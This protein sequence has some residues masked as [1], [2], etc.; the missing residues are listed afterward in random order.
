M[1]T[2]F[3]TFKNNIYKDD[4]TGF[5]KFNFLPKMK[6]DFANPFGWITCQGS[7]PYYSAD[8]PLK[9]EGEWND[10]RVFVVHKTSIYSDNAMVIANYIKNHCSGFGDKLSLNI[11]TTLQGRLF[12]LLDVPDGAEIITE[13]V[14]GISLKKANKLIE[15]LNNLTHQQVV[16]DY[17]AKYDICY[18]SLIKLDS[19]YGVNLEMPLSTNPYKSGRLLDL[20]FCDVD[21][22]AFYYNIEPYSFIRLEGLI[23]TA[24]RLK[25]NEGHTIA[26]IKDIYKTVNKISLEDSKYQCE[27][28]KI[29]FYTTILKSQL[30]KYVDNKHNMV[31]LVDLDEAESI[32]ASELK[33]LSMQKNTEDLS[34]FNTDMEKFLLA[35]ETE[36]AITLEP[37]Q[38]A[39][40]NSIKAPG[41]KIITGGPGTGKTTTIK[42]ILQFF[43][44]KYPDK[45]YMLVSPT[46]RAAQRM[47]ETTGESA[48]TIHKGID[49]KPF[50]HYNVS[51]EHCNPI[52]ADLLIVDEMSM[53]D[54]ELFSMLLKAVK[55]G[56]KVILIGDID[57]L[58]SVGAGA[59]L[60]DLIASECFETYRLKTCKRQ[61]DDNP[62]IENALRINTGNANLMTSTNFKIYRKKDAESIA[63]SIEVFYQHLFDE[64]NKMDLQILSSTKKNEAGTFS[65]NKQLQPLVNNETK[66]FHFGKKTFKLHDKV[67]MIVNRADYG[68]NNGDVGEIVEI[69]DP[70]FQISI[71]HEILTLDK[72]CANDMLR[73]YAVTAHKS[74]GSEYP[75]VIVALPKYP[76]AL[77]RRKVLFT[78]I[79]RAKQNVIIFSENDALELAIANN[80]D[81]FRMTTL[82]EK[83]LSVFNKKDCV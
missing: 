3:G 77:L 58:P 44:T 49:F 43:K 56:A 30:F 76:K 60:K 24:L 36:F 67:M 50:K 57:Q 42:A 80:E 70:T 35:Y 79:T 18:A 61:S 6:V 27:I 8:T 53:V 38:K 16:F 69:S 33:R 54:V 59:V 12:E 39:S 2:I 1:S 13:E 74:Q 25:A 10:E 64:N 47:A 34:S 46:G 4:R 45:T 37:E 15:E 32:I 62:I 82:T 23:Y 51:R 55:N 81:E 75:T 63:K 7:I 48:S 14:K 5:A 21:N 65:L 22:I 31:A 72:G 20:P 83:I 52:E 29:L 9:L 28:P 73:A 40:L 78:E 71:N 11:G 19:Y 41:V 17:A 68:Y 66:A 26:Y